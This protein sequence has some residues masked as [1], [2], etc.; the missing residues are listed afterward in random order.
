[1]ESPSISEE[2]SAASEEPAAKTGAPAAAPRSGKRRKSTMLEQF[3]PDARA[4]T[5]GSQGLR[6]STRNQKMSEFVDRY[7]VEVEIPAKYIHD[8]KIYPKDPRYL[9]QVVGFCFPSADG[10]GEYIIK[11]HRHDGGTE[12]STCGEFYGLDPRVSLRLMKQQDDS[13]VPVQLAEESESNKNCSDVPVV[14]GRQV[15]TLFSPDGR[16]MVIHL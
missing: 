3:A 11:K 16:Y 4:A 12:E 15:N 9:V 1:M 5:E 10:E 6:E 14:L 8:C 13:L 7:G 2:E